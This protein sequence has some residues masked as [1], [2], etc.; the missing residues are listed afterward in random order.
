MENTLATTL[1]LYGII[2][3]NFNTLHQLKSAMRLHAT[4]AMPT[5]LSIGEGFK[6]WQFHS[7]RPTFKPKKQLRQQFNKTNQKRIR[8]TDHLSVTLSLKTRNI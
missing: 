1:T 8:F 6:K 5:A 4:Q 3:T 7:R 2:S